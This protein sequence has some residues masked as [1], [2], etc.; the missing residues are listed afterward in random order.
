MPCYKPH[1]FL[2]RSSLVLSFASHPD[3]LTSRR[4]LAGGN[5][6][7]L[8]PQH[9][10]NTRHRC[11]RPKWVRATPPVP[12]PAIP[13]CPMA[14]LKSQQTPRLAVSLRSIFTSPPRLPADSEQLQPW[15]ESPTAE[16]LGW[17]RN[18]LP[19]L[20]NPAPPGRG[21]DPFPDSSLGGPPRFT[22]APLRLEGLVSCL[23]VWR[24]LGPPQ[25]T[26]ASDKDA[27]PRCC[28]HAI[29]H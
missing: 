12:L 18:W 16:C 4:S 5:V 10:A 14:F 19:W 24:C 1:E 17:R 23:A 27:R 20:H 9:G 28:I 6:G 3:G 21:C 25:L 13:Q 15:R 26:P 22:G 8:G 7:C 29:L 11:R 2:R